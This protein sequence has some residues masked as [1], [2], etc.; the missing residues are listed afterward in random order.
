[1]T[2]LE[3]ARI[4]H[5]GAQRQLVQEADQ[6]AAARRLNAARTVGAIA[7]HADDEVLRT[8]LALRPADEFKDFAISRKL[9]ADVLRL[10][11]PGEPLIDTSSRT[12]GEIATLI[13]GALATRSEAVG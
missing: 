9:N 8:R 13:R 12:P 3:T 2:L 1:V 11:Y 6:A 7:L 10:R 5:D 4:P